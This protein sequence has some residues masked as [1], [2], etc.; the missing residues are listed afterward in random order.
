MKA[1]KWQGRT[2]QELIIEV[3]EAL[4]CESVGEREL[5]AIQAEL[6]ET[7][8]VGAVVSPATIAREVADEGAILRH[9]EVMRCDTNWREQQLT[10][11]FAV[12]ELEFGS[13]ASAAASLSA[14]EN[15]R[16]SAQQDRNQLK[17][18]RLRELM[19]RCRQEAMLVSRSKIATDQERLIAKEVAHWLSVWLEQPELFPD[20]LS[21]RQR[22]SEYQRKFG[23]A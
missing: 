22:S 10:E 9:P 20:W 19:L 21:L 2:R 4:D 1:K 16:L 12:G 13:L 14:V 7:L 17:L 15:V 23:N 8:G 5:L 6:T 3:W 11:L 18:R